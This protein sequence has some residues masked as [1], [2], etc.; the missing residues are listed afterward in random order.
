M[1]ELPDIV[2]YITALESRIVGQRLI[3]VRVASTFL[4]RSAQPPIREVDG[5]VVRELR[6]VTHFNTGW[7][8]CK[9]K[10]VAVSPTKSQ[11]FTRRWPSMVV[12]GNHARDVAKRF[13]VSAT[14]I[15]RQTTAPVVRQAGSFSPIAV[16]RGSSDRSGRVLSKNSRHSP[17]ADPFTTD[18]EAR[19]PN[20]ELDMPVGLRY[21][22]A[23]L[24]YPEEWTMKLRLTPSLRSSHMKVLS[25]MVGVTVIVACGSAEAS[26]LD[27]ETELGQAI[28][29]LRSAIGNHPRVLK[30]EVDPDIVTVEAQ[31]SRN[32]EHVNRWQCVNRVLGFIPMRWV[33]GPEAVDLQLLDP[34]LE[35]NLFDLNAVDFSAMS[36][37]E[38]AAIEHAQMQD[39]AVVTSMEIARQ[40]FL[41]PRPTS[42]DIR[43]TLHI[44]SGREHADV[45]ASAQGVITGADLSGTQRA[46]SLNL[47]KEPDL[48]VDAAKAFRAAIGAEPILTGVGIEEKMVSFGTNIRD[49]GFG[50]LIGD[51]PATCSYS[52]DLDGLIQRLG[53]IDVNAQMG[54]QGPAPF[55]VDDVDWTILAKLEANSLA[56]V[57]I[58]QAQVTRIGIE[59]SSAAPGGPVLAWTVEVTD[60]GGEITSVVADNKGAIERVVLPESRRPKIVWLD[61][62]ALAGAISRVGTIFGPNARIASIVADDKSGR[63]T[64][65]DPANGGRPATFD[66]SADGVTRAGMTFSIG[67]TG[68]RFGVTDLASLTEQ[69]IATLEAEALKKLGKNKMVYLES[70]SIGPHPFVRD[71]GARAIEVRVRDVPEDSAKAEYGW[72]VYDFN[73]HVL[74]FVTPD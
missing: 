17:D 11:H 50:K 47:F 38:K 60:A 53:R 70:V 3:R 61:P 56:K 24:E 62:A 40:T 45:F 48:M 29:A 64:V 71:A 42:S 8:A 14:P 27:N 1:P 18:A 58:P 57:A 21:S 34:D 44:T 37:L 12:M 28:P 20:T 65:D 69:K 9:T 2:T 30:I 15:T 52:W 23:S 25:A 13:C 74:D 68:P 59:K 36:K 55:S 31:D 6:R 54:T 16:Y 41:V 49:T 7:I 51:M 10:P 73:G 67:S 39:A 46:K 33:T 66:L 4:L 63:I 72:I 5:R 22:S 43:W 32:P 19:T 35:A 26:F